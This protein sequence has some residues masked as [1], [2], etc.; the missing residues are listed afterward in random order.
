MSGKSRHKSRTAD[1]SSSCDS[2]T[3]LFVFSNGRPRPMA[4]ASVNSVPKD[5]QSHK[6][7]KGKKQDSRNEF[8]EY[9]NESWHPAGRR[10]MDSITRTLVFFS[11]AL[12]FRDLSG[13]VFERTKYLLLD[14]LG[15]AIAGSLTESSQPIYRMLARPA[16]PGPCTVI[17]TASQTSPE[18]AALAN[19]TAA[20][21]IE[22][23]D[24]HQASSLHPGVVMFSTAIA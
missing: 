20:H 4:S 17:G 11:H 15:V 8:V 10:I 22:L 3:K 2:S 18:S 9:R 6:F 5:K 1:F 7:T 24:T 12:N 21:S 13:E 16:S 23:D 19:G 14:Y